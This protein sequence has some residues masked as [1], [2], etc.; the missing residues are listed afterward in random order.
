MQGGSAR[1][2]DAPLYPQIPKSVA[3]FFPHRGKLGLAPLSSA[4]RL[5]SALKTAFALI[6]VHPSYARQKAFFATDEHR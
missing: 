1:F 6:L 3:N 2:S 4:P 5:S